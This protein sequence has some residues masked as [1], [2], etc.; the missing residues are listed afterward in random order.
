M[1][2]VFDFWL[3]FCQN[4]RDR[5]LRKIFRGP[6]FGPRC[7][8]Q[9]K[10]SV[11]QIAKKM[12]VSKTVVHNAIMKFQNKS[13]FINR[14]RSGRARVTTSREDCLIRTAVTH[15]PMSNSKKNVFNKFSKYLFL[16]KFRK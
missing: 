6:R 14:K 12:K 9:F 2:S 8:K 13:V 3:D 10:F 15:F 16:T 4:G 11:R 7:F 5:A 1:E